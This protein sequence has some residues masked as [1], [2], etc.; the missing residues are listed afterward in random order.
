MS[1]AMHVMF[2]QLMLVQLWLLLQ[3][4]ADS[5][6]LR[7]FIQTQQTLHPPL[8]NLHM[9]GLVVRSHMLFWV[10]NLHRLWQAAR[11]YIL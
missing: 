2:M 4:A 6:R 7:M 3:Q 9:D 5:M 8:A 10:D 11:P 1:A